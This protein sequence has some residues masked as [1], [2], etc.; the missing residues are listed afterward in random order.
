MYTPAPSMAA[1]RAFIDNGLLVGCGGDDGVRGRCTRLGGGACVGSTL[2]ALP[3]KSDRAIRNASCVFVGICVVLCT[4]WWM[5]QSRTLRSTLVG[6]VTAAGCATA[7]VYT[8]RCCGWVVTVV[9]ADVCADVSTAGC[10]GCAS[11]SSGNASWQPNSAAMS[12]SS[13]SRIVKPATPG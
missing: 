2:E 5:W 6:C 1:R 12:S 10:W 11:T 7:G 4:F 9:C 3:L 8:T 13:R